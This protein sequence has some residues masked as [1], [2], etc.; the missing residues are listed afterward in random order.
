MNKTE[1]IERLE[2][3]IRELK[4]QLITLENSQEKKYINL[5]SSLTYISHQFL[6]SKTWDSNIIKVLASIG[7][8]LDFSHI[9]IFE[10]RDDNSLQ[11]KAQWKNHLHKE[12]IENED[13]DTLDLN[14]SG[15]IRYLN[16]MQRGVIIKDSL[17][18]FPKKE[19]EFFAKKNIKS[20]IAAPLFV[21]NTIQG[22]IW[23]HDSKREHPLKGFESQ[24]IKDVCNLIQ[25]AYLRNEMN[26]K[27][28]IETQI[29]QKFYN[30]SYEAIV[31]IDSNGIIKRV[32]DQFV[33]LFE[34]GCDEILGKNIDEILPPVE[35][36]SDAKLLTQSILN[37]GKVLTEGIRRPKYGLP[38]YVEITGTPIQIENDQNY[39]IGVY[40][41][42]TLRKDANRK[43]KENKIKYE[44]LFENA[45]DAIVLMK[46]DIIVDCNQK[47]CELF[48]AKKN[49]IIGESIIKFSAPVQENGTIANNLNAAYNLKAINGEKVQFEWVHR[50][51]NDEIIQAEITLNKLQID[52]N[53]YIQGMIHDITAR[54]KNQQD[55]EKAKLKVEESDKLKTAFLAHISHEIRT[56]LNHILGSI[57]L[58]T[59]PDIPEETKEEFRQIIKHSSDNLLNLISDIIDISLIDSNQLEIHSEFIQIE[60][61]I[62]SAKS[63]F[64]KAQEKYQKENLNFNLNFESSTR[65]NELYSDYSRF[66]QIIHNL[67]D[68]AVKF[69]EKGMVEFGCNYQD[70]DDIFT[71]YVKDTGIGIDSSQ[72]DLIFDRFRQVDYAHT[73]EYEGTGLGLAISKEVIKAMGGDIWIESEPEVGTTFFFTLQNK[74]K[75]EDS[76]DP[77]TPKQL[78]T[79]KKVK[80]NM[81]DWSNKSILLVEDEEMNVQL[82]KTILA[83]TNV[84]LDVARNGAEGIFYVEGNKYDLVLMDMQLPEIDGYEATRKI[85]SINKDLPIIAQTA[86]VLYEDQAR[87]YE[88]GCNAYIPKPIQREKLLKLIQS[89]F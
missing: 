20:F 45:T 28:I 60:E 82:I 68:N 58:I 63:F 3:K 44:A 13:F 76:K 32:D 39:V 51:L 5:G 12:Y 70:E 11:K 48:K 84:R 34:Y 27:H 83:K 22:I 46:H 18:D 75:K 64:E 41:N 54:K 1:N 52:R 7:E 62:R 30:N 53:T 78:T 25:A 49:E 86:H 57:D 43:L 87:C 65:L 15:L 73:R 79:T 42:I 40:K 47:T 50:A 10:F 89:L 56:P 9:L 17:T 80:G 2:N 23:L 77:E 31:I 69:T 61:I 72:F 33:R 29:L 14:E 38:I 59:D 19:Q 8:A 36:I 35:S 88:V 66:E 85:K 71:F 6:V 74:K 81:Y 16:I 37:G 55:L 67:I 26:R 24:Y 4:D 21:K